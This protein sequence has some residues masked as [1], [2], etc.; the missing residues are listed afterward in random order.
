MSVT[1]ISVFSEPDDFQ[2]ALQC[3]GRVEFLV[4]AG[5]P[6]RARLTSAALP[7]LRLVAVEE[8]L[9]RIAFVSPPAGWLVIMLPVDPEGSQI[10][11]GRRLQADEIFM[12]CGEQGR[13]GRTDRPCR[14]GILCLPE[15]DLIRYSRT[16]TGLALAIPASPCFLRP[17]RAA[18]QSLVALYKAAIRL[19]EARPDAAASD[20]A[21][22][23]LQQELL[24]RLVDSLSNASVEDTTA[25]AGGHV[26]LMVRLEDTIRCHPG[27]LPRVAALCAALGVSARALQ[28]YCR[29]Y[30]G[31]SPGRY[32]RLRLL[33]RIHRALRSAES[34][35][36]TVSELARHH[37][38]RQL[39]RFAG[40]YR[41][42][43][44]EPPSATLRRYGPSPGAPQPIR[45]THAA[46]PRQQD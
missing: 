16:V 6:F 18:L 45:E 21:L 5:T 26:D 41:A 46:P 29:K 44:G 20:A 3:G 9:P 40:T 32:L 25:P 23:G 31:M 33:Q 7:R 11:A 34:P 43:Y 37:G 2:V 35:A 36:A 27:A 38:F 22:R 4:T 24:A 10:W 17:P 12:L 15:A 13:H 42:Q 28:V 14:S 19:I 30:L 39:G 1:T 8:W